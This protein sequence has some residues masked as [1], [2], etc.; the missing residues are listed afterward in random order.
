MFRR[1]DGCCLLPSSSGCCLVVLLVICLAAP[2]FGYYY[3]TTGGPEPLYENF[4]PSELEAAQYETAFQI[5]LRNAANN[6]RFDLT[7]TDDQFAS[8]LN[9]RYRDEVAD[10]TGLQGDELEFQARFDNSEVK[11]F[12]RYRLYRSVT[13]NSLATLELRP[14]LTAEPSEQPLEVVVK[15]L[16][17]GRFEGTDSVEADISRAINNALNDQL[18]PIAGRYIIEIVSINDGFLR[19]TG[20]IVRP[21]SQ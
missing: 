11:V 13:V 21:I 17:V 9:L 3:L 10:V 7:V 1:R 18:E 19:M 12:S 8:W 15:N 20:R 14:A 5:A 16:Q 6:N 4:E 2:L